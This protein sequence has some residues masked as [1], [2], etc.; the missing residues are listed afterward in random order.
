[1]AEVRKRLLEVDLD[2]EVVRRLHRA[3]LEVIRDD[4]VRICVTPQRLVQQVRG[5]AT[6]ASR[7]HRVLSAEQR[8]LRRARHLHLQA[9]QRVIPSARLVEHEEADTAVREGH[10]R[11]VDVP[12]D[13]ALQL[14]ADRFEVR[15]RGSQLD[16]ESQE[17]AAVL[18]IERE[19]RISFQALR[20]DNERQRPALVGDARAFTRQVVVLFAIRKVAEDRQSTDLVHGRFEREHA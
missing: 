12:A 6:Q 16:L 18:L 5:H 19:V 2:L 1:M 10:L 20:V 7:E 17:A 3:K 11:E 13:P 4:R 14:L 9:T 15:L 8:R